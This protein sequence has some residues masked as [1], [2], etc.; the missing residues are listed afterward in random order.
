MKYAVL[1]DVHGNLNALRSVMRSIFEIGVDGCILLGDLVDY[2]M[3]SN[4]CIELLKSSDVDIICNIW[5]NHEYSI[6]NR[7]YDRFS[8]DRGKVSAM[9][10]RDILSSDSMTYL[11]EA[12]EHSGTFEFKIGSKSCLA[13]HG[14]ISDP[15]W[16]TLDTLGFDEAYGAFDYVFSGHS[17]VPHYFER[18][19]V[20][21]NP[22][23]RNKKKTVFVNPGSVGQP[24]N[25]DS[26][27][28]YAIVDFATGD[29]HMMKAEYDISDEQSYFDGSVDDFYR[30]RISRGV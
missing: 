19:Y 4:E 26:R 9:H 7:T 8:S 30:S 1:S 28:Q 6:M 20:C 16:G 5:G 10:T 13:L 25:L 11:V 14:S 2:G 18:F 3:R 22:E 27:S 12:M 23:T 15:L 29:V 24:R 17:H 21:D